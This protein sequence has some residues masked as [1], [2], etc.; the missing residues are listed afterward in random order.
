MVN[1]EAICMGEFS[2]HEMGHKQVSIARYLGDNAEVV[3]PET[4]AGMRVC[5]PFHDMKI[6]PCKSLLY[7]P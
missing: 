2:Y 3:I 5:D 1:T 4:L 6:H 7:L